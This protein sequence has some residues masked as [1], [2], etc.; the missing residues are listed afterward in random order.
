MNKSAQYPILPITLAF[1]ILLYFISGV[2]STNN[3]LLGLSLVATIIIS[4]VF[5]YDQQHSIFKDKWIRPSNIL[6]LGLLIVESQLVADVYFGLKKTGEFPLEFENTINLC[7]IL[8]VVSYVAFLIG[9]RY[10]YR[11]LNKQNSRIKNSSYNIKLLPFVLL[12]ILFLY[13]WISTVDIV[14]L[15]TGIEY[16][17][18][19]GGG[20]V[21]DYY[22]GLFTMATY[23][24][25]ISI[26]LNNNGKIMSTKQYL[27]SFPLLSWVLLIAYLGLRLVSGDRG[28]VIYTL[29]IYFYSYIY[30]TKKNIRLFYVLIMGASAAIIVSLIGIARSDLSNGF[31]DSF[32]G[33]ASSYQEGGRFGRKTILPPTEEL[34][35]SFLC[36]EIAIDEI[37]NKD[38][39]FHYGTYQL[40]YFMN[41]IPFAPSFLRK[42]L[43]IKEKDLSSSN[44]ITTSYLGDDPLYGLGTTSLADF[45]LDFGVWGVAIGFFVIG[46]LFVKVDYFIF[47]STRISVV[48]AAAFFSLASKAIYIPRSTLLFQFQEL[49]LLCVL[50]FTF[51]YINKLFRSYRR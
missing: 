22:E 42:T 9:Y 18:N 20:R 7:A 35:N 12:Q 33:A 34:A 15:L 26:S 8:A 14:A 27:F 40:S 36:N 41:M 25:P 4:I 24:I 29:L 46:L 3:M 5:I 37:Y 17:E 2:G 19:E 30:L 50:I 31:S 23:A 43:K 10:G 48:T 47:F 21:A 28:P 13:L 51:N 32:K 39:D 49:F 45:F 38:K 6:F 1:F 16:L 44:L 11:H